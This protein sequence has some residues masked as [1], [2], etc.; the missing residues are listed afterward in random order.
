MLWNIDVERHSIAEVT[1][2]MGITAK[3][4]VI[5][6]ATARL[7]F[8]N[9][10]SELQGTN[11]RFSRDCQRVLSP[12]QIAKTTATG[13]QRPP[14]AIAHIKGCLRCA[15]LVDESDYLTQHLKET[16][17]PLLVPSCN[18]EPTV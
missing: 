14:Q 17:A 7:R 2:I 13:P 16:L 18:L 15:I 12:I 8:R 5:Q 4:V 10:W 1:A 3:D 11:P 9:K 6:L